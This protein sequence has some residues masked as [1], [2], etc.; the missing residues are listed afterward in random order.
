MLHANQSDALSAKYLFYSFIRR[1]VRGD[2]TLIQYYSLYLLLVVWSYIMQP[3]GV[4]QKSLK[5]IINRRPWQN[6]TIPYQC[7]GEWQT[8]TKHTCTLYMYNVLVCTLVHVHAHVH[9]TQFQMGCMRYRVIC[10]LATC[11]HFVGPWPPFIIGLPNDHPHPYA[12]EPWVAICRW[13]F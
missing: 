10:T 9:N 3:A 8:P 13:L 11:N 4:C 7:M 12:Y 1:Q 5:T 2:I 6:H